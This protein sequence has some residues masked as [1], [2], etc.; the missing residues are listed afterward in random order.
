LRKCL[1]A[2]KESSVG[3]HAETLGRERKVGKVTNACQREEV[4]LT[5][6]EMAG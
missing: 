1:I 6:N 4:P 3:S 5:Q 2:A